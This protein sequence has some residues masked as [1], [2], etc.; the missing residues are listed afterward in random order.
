MRASSSTHTTLPTAAITRAAASRSAALTASA[1]YRPL[2]PAPIKAGVLGIVRTSLACPP[3]QRDRS[4]SR[5]PAAMLITNCP[6]SQGTSG[7][8]AAR[9]CCGLTASTS[10][11]QSSACASAAAW[12]RTP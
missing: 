10:T 12:Q 11:S 7:A 2:T 5:K 3:S 1:A 9:I 4:A 8:Q 6:L